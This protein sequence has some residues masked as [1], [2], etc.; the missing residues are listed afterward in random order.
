VK[1]AGMIIDLAL[2]SRGLEDG[3]RSLEGDKFYF[4][5]DLVPNLLKDTEIYV[6][7]SNDSKEWKCMIQKQGVSGVQI[8]EDMIRLFKR[9]ESTSIT[10]NFSRV[11]EEIEEREKQLGLDRESFLQSIKY[12]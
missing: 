8:T 6:T 1:D 2:V 11:I 7:Y 5:D 12:E 10:L 4:D 3:E 9:R